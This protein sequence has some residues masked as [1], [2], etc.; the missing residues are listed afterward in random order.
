MRIPAAC[1]LLFGCLILWSQPRPEIDLE[2]FAEGLFQVQDDDI[3]YEELYESLLLYYTSPINLNKTDREELSTLYLLSPIQLNAFF[4]YREQNG[5]LLSLYELQAIP[6]MDRETIENLRPFVTVRES[7]DP[8]PL[9]TRILEE[10]NNYLLL[11]YTRTIQEQEGYKRSDGSGYLGDPNTLYGRFRVSHPDDF[12]LGFTFEKDAGE[13][14][15]WDPGRRQYGFDYYSGHFLLENKGIIK[16]LA[17]GD[18]Q[19]QFGQG[20]VLGSGFGAGKGAETTQAV[21]RNSVG[22]RPYSSALEAGFFR[23]VATT[24]KFGKLETSLFASRLR[25]A[26]NLLNDTTYSDF[27]EF[28][29]SIQTTGFHRTQNEL[30]AKDQIAETSAGLAAQYQFGRRLTV[31]VTGLYTHYSTPLQKKPNNYNQYEFSG[32]HNGISSLF[33]TYNWQNFI[34]FGEAGISTSGGIGVVGGFISSLTPQID[35]SMVAR[36]YDR[37]FHSFYGNAFGESSRNI[38]EK[39]IYWGLKFTPN[40]RCQFAL[41]FDK[42]EFPWLRFRVEAPSDGYEYLGRFT[43]KPTRNIVLYAQYR[44]EHK[45]LTLAP[46]GG[47]TN[48][49]IPTLK[50]N[51]IFNIDY[52]LGRFFS[53]KTRIQG[54]SYR[55]DD[56]RST[57]VAIIQDLN[58]TYRQFRFSTRY[59]LFDADDFNN[60]QYVYERDVLYA[61]SLPAYNGTGIRNYFLIQYN[62]TRNLR[63]YTRY[64]QFTF[65]DQE[66]V[67]SGLGEINGNRRSEMKVM[68]RYKF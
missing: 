4:E 45:E 60:R 10:E 25:Q 15:R 59:A 47:N 57:G 68:V 35:F 34:L 24:F 2:S 54:S 61:F 64:A 26:A 17:I 36:N 66:S 19:L 48:R 62:V 11:R 58:F 67:G 46:E 23:G 18:Y 53:L 44:E 41:Y 13:T 56:F 20:L 3:Y 49:L 12:S 22:I 51:Y 32:D 63:I 16:T 5:N 31:G 50:R 14:F 29:N 28:V 21:K 37:N 42:F 39:G 6:G 9:I 43:Y 1:S 27:D 40:R 33:G 7:A 8:R 55:E 30:N 38:N 65:V 52:S